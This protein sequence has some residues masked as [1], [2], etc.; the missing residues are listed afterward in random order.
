MPLPGP[1]TTAL[2]TEADIL[3]YGGSAGGGKSDLLIGAALTQHKRSI[4]YRRESVQLQGIFDRVTEI[5]GSRDGFNSQDKIWRLKDR[6]IEFGSCKNLGDEIAYQGR[7][8]DLK[9]F[10]EITHFTE[11]Q[12]RFL[13][14]WLRSDNPNIRQRVICTGNPPTDSDGEWVTRFWGPWLDPNYPN[15][16][17]PGEL[18]WFAMIDGTETEVDSEPF[19][20]KGDVITPKSRTFIPSKVTDNPYLMETGYKATLQ[21]LPEPLRSQMLNGDFMAGKEDNAYQCIP[22]A[23]VEAAMDRWEPR[24]RKGKMSSMGVDPARGGA[25]E[26]VISR[27]F[28]DWFDELLVYPGKQTPDGGSV[29][30]LIVQNR[31]NNCPVHI[32]GIGI[33]SSVVDHCQDNGIQTVSVIWSKASKEKDKTASFGFTNEKAKCWWRMRE[34]LDPDGDVQIALPPDEELKRDLC[35]PRWKMTSRGVQIESKDDIVKRIGR[36]TDRG[37]AVVYAHI[38]TESNTDFF[39]PLPIHTRGIV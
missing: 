30:T 26:T 5:L 24:T 18:R 38:N 19:E 11:L 13:N 12:F 15:P 9:G 29:T 34:A 31:K 17:E 36:S 6:Q 1:Q 39:K 32:D 37:D 4:I 28:G 20:H 22:T 27:R 8:H 35:V 3:F 14:G 21:A 10:D 23:W 16:A 2:N 33:G 7:P 25:D